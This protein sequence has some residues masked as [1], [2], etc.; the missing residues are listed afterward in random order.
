MQ[1]RFREGVVE[2]QFS[3]SAKKFELSLAEFDALGARFK[4]TFE[5]ACSAFGK[6]LFSRS[7][8]AFVASLRKCQ[9][10]LSADEYDALASRDPVGA[11]VD[12][13][14]RDCEL[15]HVMA[16]LLPSCADVVVPMFAS[17]V[18]AE[19]ESVIKAKQVTL[20]FVHA[21]FFQLRASSFPICR[22]PSCHRSTS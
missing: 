22:N 13:L 9:Y 14:L 2:T 3:S 11:A 18:L 15:E 19:L 1:R 20:R 5:S 10:I 6:S 7:S 12:A 17:A 21:A 4:R 16:S 8:A